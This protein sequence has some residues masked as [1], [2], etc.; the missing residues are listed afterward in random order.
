MSAK[1]SSDLAHREQ[2][3]QNHPS[4]SRFHWDSNIEHKR[5]QTTSLQ[6]Q[7]NPQFRDI[8]RFQCIEFDGC[9]TNSNILSG[10]QKNG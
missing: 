5:M 8:A 3:I 2:P 4:S 10:R 1:M 6:L 9:R 7:P